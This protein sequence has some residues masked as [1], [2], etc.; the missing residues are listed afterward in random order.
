MSF[1]I[2]LSICMIKFL[3]YLQI[4]VVRFFYVTKKSRVEKPH[5][6]KSNKSFVQEGINVL[7]VLLWR[8][9]CL[10]E[11]RNYV[12][13]LS[14][15]ISMRRSS[16]V[17]VQ[18]NVLSFSSSHLALGRSLSHQKKHSRQHSMRWMNVMIVCAISSTRCGG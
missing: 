8:F 10:V 13:T 7:T 1:F 2:T 18:G 6:N 4:A 5:C 3:L 15:R 16:I 12:F 17:K 14:K 11:L 9:L